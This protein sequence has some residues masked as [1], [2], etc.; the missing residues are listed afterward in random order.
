MSDT[1]RRN[2]VPDEWLLDDDESDNSP[3]KVEK[4]PEGVKYKPGDYLKL[5]IVA[6]EASGDLLGAHL[7]RALK[8]E[9]KREIHFFGIGGDKMTAEGLDSLFPF[10][11]LS[12]MGFVE[13][14]PYI[15]N[16]SARINATVDDILA[17][18]PAV[19]VTIDSPGFCFRVV[20]KLRKEGFKGKF[21]HYVAPTVWAYKPERAEKC[22]ELFDHMLTLLP[23]EKPY[24]DKV[25][26]KCTWVGHPVVAET[27]IG[28]GEA[29]RQKYQIT[30]ETLLLAVLPGSRKGEVDRHMPIFAKAITLLARQYPKMAISVAVPKNVINF[31]APYFENCPFRAVVAAGE[32]DKKDAIAAAN[33]ALVK[34]GTVALEV[35]KAGTPMI[36]AYRVNP[37]SAW[38]LK[39]M[40]LTK[41]V[42]LINIILK[43]ELIPELLQELCTPLMIASAASVLLSDPEKQRLQKQASK[44]VLQQLLPGSGILPSDIAAHVILQFLQVNKVA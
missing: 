34:S 5:Y 3:Q 39:R 27:E 9:S 28:N 20:S 24:F 12:M 26:L 14:L 1:V 37:I 6:G 33:I 4:L 31:V 43:K 10:Y 13:V 18:Q 42:N 25:G 22:A 2:D 40:V 16:L 44:D 30:P 38:L 11:E 23:F 15:F 29:F 8:R 7:M 17:K 32:E 21:I 36:V 35:A 19:V 41:Y